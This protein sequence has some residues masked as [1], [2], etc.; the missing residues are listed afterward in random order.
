MFATTAYTELNDETEKV[1]PSFC[2]KTATAKDLGKPACCAGEAVGLFGKIASLFGNALVACLV[3]V[4]VAGF[5]SGLVYGFE[6][7]IK[8]AA[9]IDQDAA[10]EE[11]QRANLTE[12]T[13]L[14]SVS[15]VASMYNPYLAKAV[16]PT[17]GK[18]R[19]R[20]RAKHG[21]AGKLTAS[22]EFYDPAAWAAAIQID[23]R[24]IFRGVHYGRLY[25]AAYALVECLGKRAIVKINDVGPLRPGRVI[26]LDQRS[27]RYFD[28]SLRAGLIHDVKITLLSGDGWKPGPVETVQPV[29]VAAAQLPVAGRAPAPH[30]G[31]QPLVVDAVELSSQEPETEPGES[32]SF[33]IVAVAQS[34]EHDRPPEPVGGKQLAFVGADELYEPDLGPFGSAPF[35]SVVAE[36]RANEEPASIARA[37]PAS[38]AAPR[39]TAPQPSRKI[40]LAAAF[41]LLSIGGLIVALPAPAPARASEIPVAKPRS[42][43]RRKVMRNQSRTRR[44]TRNR[45]GVRKSERKGPS[46]RRSKNVKK[47]SAKKVRRNRAAVR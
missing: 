32:Q 40:G 46:G 22:G 19:S 35:A 33:A 31:E 5:F 12:E 16:S 37:E 38:V 23:L 42:R 18:H 1:R 11:P 4:V 34:P 17:R 29:V 25:Q 6:R 43:R 9:R 14:A 2:R 26:D 44:T 39:I 13:M 7:P 28:P 30:G 8:T 24:E 21:S 20:R 27:M 47:S 10:D 15:G 41:V 45:K 36:K 3:G